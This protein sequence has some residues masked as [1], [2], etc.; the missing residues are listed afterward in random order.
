MFRIQFEK[1]RYLVTYYNIFVVLQVSDDG[2]YPRII[3]PKCKNHL[4]IIVKFI[5]ELLA[6]QSF[7]KN[8][9]KMYESKQFSTAEFTNSDIERTVHIKENVN[10]NSTDVEFVCETCGLRLAHENDLKIHMEN[11]HGRYLAI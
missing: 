2:K 5:D 8:I 11:H 1:C 3:C 10:T 7:L 6:G 9:H 4:D